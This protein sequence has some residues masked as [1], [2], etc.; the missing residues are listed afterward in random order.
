MYTFCQTPPILVLISHCCYNKLPQ[1]CWLKTTQI[2][3]VTVLEVESLKARCGMILFLLEASGESCV[4]AFPASR[5]CLSSSAT[6][7]VLPSLQTLATV[8]YHLLHLWLCHLLLQQSLWSYLGCS[9]II[10]D[11]PPISRSYLNHISKVPFATS[12]NIF[13][14]SGIS[15]WTPVWGY[16]SSSHFIDEELTYTTVYI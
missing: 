6:I 12:G 5:S 4:P 7:S 15:V 8:S 2:Y 3:S 9:Q 14:C 10:Q 16:Y 13:T 1:I 11:N